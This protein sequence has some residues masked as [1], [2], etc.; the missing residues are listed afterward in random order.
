[1]LR[2]LSWASVIVN[3]RSR[4]ELISRRWSFLT[5]LTKPSKPAQLRRRFFAKTLLPLQGLGLA[6]ILLPPP[7]PPSISPSSLSLSLSLYNNSSKLILLLNTHS[8][9]Y[10]IWI[11]SP[12]IH[13]EL[14]C[15]GG[16]FL[17]FPFFF[18]FLFNFYGVVSRFRF[19]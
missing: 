6:D 10:S 2:N 18:D 12:S 1:M 7:P 16:D 13:C 4:L 17:F 9:S 8:I 15:S 11:L 14:V 19:K 5:L 3:A